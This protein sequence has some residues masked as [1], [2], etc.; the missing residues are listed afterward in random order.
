M[1]NLGHRNA[2]RASR[3]KVGRLR[4]LGRYFRD[5]RA[6]FFGKAFVLFA[7]AYVVFPLDAIPDVAPVVGWLDDI[8]VVSLALWHLSRVLGKYRQDETDVIEA[9]VVRQAI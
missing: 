6:S 1:A 2:L 7:V 8:G 5:D 3:G 9:Q 4:A